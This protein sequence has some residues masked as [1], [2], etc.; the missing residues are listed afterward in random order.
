MCFGFESKPFT[1]MFWWEFFIDI[2][3]IVDIVL[4]FRTG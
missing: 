4:N 1:R 3:F 2:I